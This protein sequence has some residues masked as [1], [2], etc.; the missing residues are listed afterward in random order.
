MVQAS[1]YRQIEDRDKGKN[2]VGQ[3]NIQYGEY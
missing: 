2:Q 3:E 1:K